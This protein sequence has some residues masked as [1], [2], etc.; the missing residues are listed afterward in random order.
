[1]NGGGIR[2]QSQDVKG[3]MLR[4]QVARRLNIDVRTLNKATKLPKPVKIGQRLFYRESDLAKLF[5][6]FFGGVN[7]ES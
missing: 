7:C 5:P 2:M 3:L 1:M 6:D 4:I